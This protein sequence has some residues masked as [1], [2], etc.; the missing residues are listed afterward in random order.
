MDRATRRGHG[1]RTPDQR[2]RVFVSS[3]L[4]EMAEERAAARRA[5]DALYLAPVMFELGARPHPARELYRAYL[6][7]SDIFIGIY[8]RRY[9]WTAPGA[10][11][12]GLEEEY[13]LSGDK[14][15]L[16]Y[17]KQA[18]AERE[19]GLARMLADIRD[20]E[21][22]S[23]KYFTSA[24]E[25][26]RTIGADLS[27]L[28][29]ERFER[30]GREAAGKTAGAVAF[31]AEPTGPG[32]GY[33]PSPPAPIVGR[34]RELASVGERLGE[35][36]L[37]T[38]TGPGG[39]GKTRL[40]VEAACGLGR[41][42]DAVC[43]VELAPITDPR[44]VAEE[45]ARALG[46]REAGSIP[47]EQRVLAHLQGRNMLLVLDNFEQVVSAAPLVARI[48]ERCPRVS[49]LA[50][51]RFALR[52]RGENELP[53]PPLSLPAAGALD[54][55][56]L[57]RHE[58]VAMFRQRARA[59]KPDFEIS[60]ENIEAVVEIC[61]RLDGLPLA[62][63][64]AAPRI[65]VLSPAALLARLEGSL[66]LLSEGAAD[67]PD[68]QRT[69]QRTIEWSY[70]LLEEPEQVLFRRL[71][72]FVGGVSLPA[73][74]ALG[75]TGAR[76]G[77]EA[78]QTVER[79]VTKNMIYQRQDRA[80]E[81]RL[82]M[83]ETIREFAR[84]RLARSGEGG[85]ILD[86]HAAF[87]TAAAEEA[88][89]HLISG[90]RDPW[91]LRLEIELDNLR[92]V[93][94]RSLE[95]TVDPLYGIR[96]A[97]TLGWFW[98]LR[99]HLSEGRSWAGSLMRLPRASGRSRERAKVL[100]PAGGLAWSQGDY[101]SCRAILSESA[102][103][104]R[105]LGDQQ[106]LVNAQAILSGGLA[107]LGDYDGALALCEETAALMRASGDLWGLAFILLW[108]GDTI[109]VRSGQA[110]EARAMFAESLKL[111]EEL[112]DDWLRAEA[113]NHLGVA[114]S[115]LSNY[116]A[117][118]GYFEESLKYHERTGDRWATARG[119]AG[120]AEA[121]LRQ[122][123]LE[124]AGQLY[125]K[126]LAVWQEMGNRPGR[127]VC[128]SALAVIAAAEGEA[129]RAARLYGAAPDPVRA[130]GYL[131]LQG[132]SREYERSLDPARKALGQSAWEAERR[133]G[134]NMS[135]DR[136]VSLALQPRVSD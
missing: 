111:S 110:A 86:A 106:G 1:I 78:L 12:S 3:T 63:E 60:P 93:M 44:L 74:Q 8:G 96:T 69:M 119:L 79:L 16:V 122:G 41:R 46:I 84:E 107:S 20:R 104:F 118:H 75:G 108:H 124:R 51:S 49:V 25:L 123:D 116:Q 39:S 64:L 11:V 57:R 15:R 105:E 68:R 67:L 97:G 38:L 33:L 129:G 35:S 120:S 76:P 48:L 85:R 59:V 100:F 103:I 134:G 45:I 112:E 87:F 91:M 9:G 72:V 43:Y 62:I 4:K 133:A 94:R 37:L 58:A 131:F 22:I 121:F 95:G 47:S 61:R 29:A 98:H 127:L 21:G 109:L 73:L 31:Q 135:P 18:G 32:P 53:V 77:Q 88:E 14:P 23:Y 132:D 6:E 125:R 71:S 114:E 83:L 130:V 70:D 81:G 115:T 82:Y 7:Q 5:I 34:E 42:F 99:G 128:L 113:L 52:L 90:R 30:S 117:V 17:I 65:R 36:R 26:E 2:L 24:E 55:E 102:D 10:E 92:A 80:A 50:T 19:P 126:S 136:A 13:R 27:L 28:L 101:L 56:T 89:P 66:P 40:A 54:P